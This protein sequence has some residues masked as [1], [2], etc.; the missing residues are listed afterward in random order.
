M[1]FATRTTL[2]RVQRIDAGTYFEV[3]RI[4]TVHITVMWQ[5]VHLTSICVHTTYKLDFVREIDGEVK[6]IDFPDNWALGFVVLQVSA[7]KRPEGNRVPG[8]QRASR[9]LS[10]I[11]M[12]CW[13]QEQSRHFVG[14][15][16]RSHRYNYNYKWNTEPN[17]WRT[18]ATPRSIP[19][20]STA[21]QHQYFI[22]TRSKRERSW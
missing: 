7:L 14:H 16:R 2:C 11:I 3:C 19:Q 13:K 6:N 4:R 22:S 15:P 21:Q 17:M 18:E 1:A 9:T 12:I 20:W 5:S 10:I 8:R